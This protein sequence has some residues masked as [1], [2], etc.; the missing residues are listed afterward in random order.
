M[1]CI[2]IKRFFN[3]HWLL[4]GKESWTELFIAR[5]F[6]I[7]LFDFWLLKLSYFDRLWITLC[8]VV[9]R[10][11]TKRQH[12]TKLKTKRQHGTKLKTKR[13]HGTQLK[14]KRQHG[15]K[16]K[17][18]RQHGT[19]LKT[20]RQHVTKLKTKRQ[21]GTKLKIYFYKWNLRHQALIFILVQHF[22]YL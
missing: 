9:Q 16:L 21:H 8:F 19:K 7:K 11:K 13:Q 1:S 20:K 3:D 2:W 12:G 5:F 18:K 15:T 4:F 22:C 10:T 6:S 14:T 17:T